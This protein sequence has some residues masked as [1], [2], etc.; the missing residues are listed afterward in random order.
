MLRVESENVGYGATIRTMKI[1]V[2]R[3]AVCAAD[4][5]LNELVIYL[6][7]ADGS[8]LR[9]CVTQVE[10]ANFLQ[11]SSSHSVITG[12]MD[13]KPAVRIFSGTDLEFLMTEDMEI[14]P[15]IGSTNLVFRFG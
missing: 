9:E 4:D 6:E 12:Y 10:R 1:S 14:A 5:Q 8:T 2:T 7:I 11:F 13:G 15:S 3:Q